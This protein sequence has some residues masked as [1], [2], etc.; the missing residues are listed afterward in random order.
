M[1][2]SGRPRVCRNLFGKPTKEESVQFKSDFNA[3]MLEE[4][5]KAKSKYNFDIDHD[6]PLL[7]PYEWIAEPNCPSFY[8]KG[9]A[10][11][12]CRPRSIQIC[13]KRKLSFSDSD[14]DVDQPQCNN[15]DRSKCDDDVQ[16]NDSGF[17]SQENSLI[18][19]PSS[20]STSKRPKKLV[21]TK[22]NNSFQCYTKGR[23]Y[24]DDTDMRAEWKSASP[25]ERDVAF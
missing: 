20:S 16:I 2:I 21:Q 6:E 23:L 1:D 22:L 10:P 12:K 8:T 25:A 5:I 7:G 9:Y 15:S 14:S 4:K 3:L 18:E 11:H 19:E 17:L 13:R 24:T